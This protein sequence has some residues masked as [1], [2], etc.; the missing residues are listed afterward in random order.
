[1]FSIQTRIFLFLLACIPAR[2]LLALLP[3][4]IDASYLRYY[5]LLLLIPTIGFLY[6][7]FTNARLNAPEGGGLTWWAEYRLIHGL[8]YLSA[9]IMAFQEKKLAW[10][11]LTIDVIL[12]LVLFLF[13]YLW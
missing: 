10:V 5:G 8:L 1:M 7:Y 13:R 2:I 12:G 11:P 3:L 9:T 6:L 4:Y